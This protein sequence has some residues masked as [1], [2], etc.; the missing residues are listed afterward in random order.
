MRW[1]NN[2]KIGTKLIASF[3]VVIA[4]FGAAMIYQ[5]S[6]LR[7][8]GTLQD[9]GQKRAQDAIT[10]GQIEMLLDEIY[11]VMADGVINRD[12][13]E[14]H[15]EFDRVKA[16][17]QKSKEAV[18]ALADTPEERLRAEIY[19]EK[20]DAMFNLMDHE[21]YPL[22]DAPGAVDFAKLTP[23]DGKIDILRGEADAALSFLST[24]LRNENE[25]GDV[26]FD[27]ERRQATLT[28]IIISIVATIAGLGC[29]IV[30]SRLITRPLAQGVAM[31]DE[32]S[33][34][35]LGTRL[36]MERAD[37]IGVLA[38]RMDSFA[39]TLQGVVTSLHSIADG[40][41]SV[42]VRRLDEKDE[43]APAMI[44][45]V[46]A[47]RAL[48]DEAGMLTKAAVEGQLQTRGD[49]KKFNGG[50]RSIVEGVNRTLD[51]V[52]VPLGDVMTAVATMAGGDMRNRMTKEYH[53]DYRKLKDSINTLGESMDK[54]LS[55]VTEAVAATASASSEISSSTEQMAAGAQ[56]QT[57][58]AT[59]VA[60]AVEQMTKTIMET[61][62]NAS[63]AAA[64]ARQA[65]ASA[66]E[67]GR[68]VLETME[69]MKR[70]AEVV[71]QSAATVQE[72]GKS[73]DQIGEIVQVIDDIADQTNLLALN[74]AIEAARA[75]EQGRGFA[76]VADEV[77]KLAER[78]TNATKEIATMIR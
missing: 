13:S 23:I 48:V 56:E 72:L 64:T 52:V 37:E 32:L 50:Y 22:L 25:E 42:D 8:L 77:R 20:L 43:I 62:K 12:M 44:S 27:E 47:L 30:I 76:V 19:T 58:Q 78:T 68:V 65:G 10:I 2:A 4:L 11:G 40:D 16:E 17:G 51:G 1:I 15:K 33:K 35:H 5:I 31:M 28:L 71:K 41:L 60:S 29:G 14:N 59:E 34:A 53:G 61:T 3:V 7:S 69:G 9:E 55:D 6:T 70:I 49:V 57:Q 26:K 45:I 18:R 63:E 74:A 46:S 21:V 36:R 67:G 39:D 75:G 54:A 24:S 38:D 66:K 73:S